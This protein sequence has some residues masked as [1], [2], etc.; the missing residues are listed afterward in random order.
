MRLMLEED[1]SAATSLDE[2]QTRTRQT[3][4]ELRDD[5]FAIHYVV[6]PISCDGE[7]N[8]PSNIEKLLAARTQVMHA[9]GTRTLVLTAPFIFSLDPNHNSYNR[10]RLF[11]MEKE[12]REAE[13]QGFWDTL[14]ESGLIDA[15]HFAEGYKRSPGAMRERRTAE[16]MSIPV[17]DIMPD[18]Q[19]ST[20]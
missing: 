14:I 4:S 19:Y 6:G 16:K 12:R 3:L 17:I 2:L 13:L 20:D 7:E 8:I 11:E 5:G 15:V 10:L 18:A 9:L 1:L